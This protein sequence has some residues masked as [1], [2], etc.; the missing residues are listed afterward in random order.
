M[1]DLLI[2]NADVLTS[3]PQTMRLVPRQ[4]I[5]I[6]GTRIEAIA[7]G[8][9]VDRGQAREVIE[10]E[11]MM[12]L[13]GFI[14]AHCHSPMVLFRGLAEDLTVESW[15]NDYIWRVEAN[16]TPEDVYWGTML[17]LVEMIEAGVT[18]VADHYFYMDEVARAIEQAG[19]RGA[20][21]WAIFSAGVSDP[22]AGLADSVKFV[23]RW[24]GAADGRITT[25]LGPHAPYTC[26]DD[27]LRL[28]AKQARAI[29]TGVHIHVSET[30]AQV[31]TS[32]AQSGRSPIAVVRDT[33][34]LEGP[35]L[36]AHAAHPYGDDIDIMARAHVGVAHCP[37]TFVK[38]ASGVAPVNA[39]RMAG[40]AVGLGSDGA[41]S[42][43]TYDLLEQMR[44][45]VLLQRHE[46][47]S[48]L[49]MPIPE[50]LRMA[51]E[52]SAR[53]VQ[54]PDLGKLAAGKLADVIL[55]QT[56]AARMHP[57]INPLANLVYSAQSSDV[58]TVIC[59]GKILM[60]GR[61]LLTL[62]KAKIIAEASSRVERLIKR[63]GAKP[64]QVYQ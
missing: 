46:T 60:R 38:M 45:A 13:P 3:D 6:N 51:F 2:R 5:V 19:T 42:N 7:A 25:W 27:F 41:A 11:S 29:D 52:D 44:L 63:D 22:A 4:D 56:T 24:R 62:D 21:A 23:E 33:G 43:N 30:K 32:L 59:N 61:Q 1:I 14:N 36:F 15:F 64:I 8:G 9:S 53:A 18:T 12:A 17:G 16:L 28:V 49:T 55:L 58:D 37:K 39:M 10:A 31:A 20:L 57:M 54:L 34:I 35:T 26:D 47:D 40:I 48:P 50:T